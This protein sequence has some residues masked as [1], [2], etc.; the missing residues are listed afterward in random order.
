[1]SSIRRLAVV[2]TALPIERTAV[3]EHLRDTYEEPPIGG[4]IYRRGVFDERSEPWDVVVADIGR[5][6]SE[7]PPRLSVSFR[8][9]LLRSHCS[10]AW[11][12]RSRT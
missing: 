11:P 8:T 7:R 2:I 10:S 1:M 12:G 5:V 4:S 6:T 9:T 3:L